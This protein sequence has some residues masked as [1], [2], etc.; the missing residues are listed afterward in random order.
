[1]D[2][3]YDMAFDLSLAYSKKHKLLSRNTAYNPLTIEGKKSVSIELFRQFGDTPDYVFVPV[4]DGVI[5]SGVYKG[6][7]DLLQFGLIEK[8]PTIVA[9]QA[10]GSAA[11]YN[12]LRDG[13]FTECASQTVADSIAV[14]IPRCG[15]YALKNLQEFKGQS[16]M[17]SD[18]EILLAQ[19]ELSEKAGLFAEPAAA[20][21]YAGYKKTQK[22]IDQNAKIAL[23]ITGSGLKDIEAATKKIRF[24]ETAITS[25]EEI[26]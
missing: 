23:L 11:I 6:F 20:A 18:N 16:V 24:P 7:K 10:E 22:D 19:K 3:N 25:I 9:V 17:V 4:G 15:Y 2:G 21:S 26:K 5:M 13:H 8:M 12:A 14:D 1:M